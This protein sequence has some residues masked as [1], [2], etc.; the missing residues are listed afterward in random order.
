MRAASG[1]A[2]GGA[3]RAAASRGNGGANGNGDDEAVR[4]A[5][6]A[7]YVRLCSGEAGAADHLAW[8]RWHNAHPSHQLAWQRIES[9][10]AS[11]QRVPAA[12]ARPTLEAANTGR[13][14][15]LR[16]VVLL[17]CAGSLSYGA[18]RVGAGRPVPGAAPWAALLADFR[19][20]T[21]EQ[22]GVELADGSH[23]TMNTRSAVDV[24]FD[25]ARRLIQLH[26]GEILLETA[27][28][29]G[30]ASV[31]SDARPFIVETGHGAIRALGTRFIVRSNADSTRVTV[32]E[33]SVEVRATSLGDPVLL[34]AGQQLSITP[35][36]AG[37]TRA[38]DPAAED[39]V[40]GSLVVND[41]RL[42]DVVTELARYHSGRLA[43]DP[44]VADIR[45]SGA[46]PIHDTDKAL[47][48]IM[49]AFPVRVLSLTRYWLS[50]VA[51]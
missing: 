26:A 6:V 48:V 22:R 14:H 5:A 28:H 17:A 41:W 4:K 20:G 31:V 2:A 51:I 13:R 11:T 44:A 47:A 8:Q 16:N 1:L 33:D 18:Y 34:R 21:G 37:P 43:C 25:S 10:R 24:A 3:K 38:A 15:V 39:W 23:M 27:R 50:V 49:Q 32:L 29:R 12:I 46:F 45:V 36:G 7:W 19:T 42:G 35:D 30:S 9:I 40:H